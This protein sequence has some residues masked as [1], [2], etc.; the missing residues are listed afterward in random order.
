MSET[1]IGKVIRYVLDSLHIDTKRASVQAVIR[2]F[3]RD[4]NTSMYK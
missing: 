1:T 3:Y 2:F 4:I